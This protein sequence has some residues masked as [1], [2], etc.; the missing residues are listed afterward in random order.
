LDGAG[1]PHIGYYDDSHAD[2]KYIRWTGSAWITQTVDSGGNVGQ[3]TSL[4]LDGAGNP[5]ISYY[6][7]TNGDLKYARWTGSAGSTALTA[8]WSIQTVDSGGDVGSHASLALDAAGNPHISYYDDTNDDLKYARW[9]A[10]SEAEGTGS[11]WNIQTVD[12]GGSVGLYTSLALDT[13]GHPHISYYAFYPAY[14]LKYARWAGS[15]WEIQTVDGAGDVGEYTSLALDSAGNPHISYYDKTNGD[16]KYAVGSPL[17]ITPTPTPTPIATLMATATPT[18]TPTKTATPTG[19]PTKTPTPTPTTG[20]GPTNTLTPTR[21]PA[22]KIYVPLILK[23]R[24][25]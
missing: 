20:P 10:L 2:L 1:Y 4:A 3:Y 7:R 5:H 16:L 24:W 14:D 13:A 21:L 22:H 18:R 8:G 11:A 17:P 25:M 23:G 12:S 19:T 6:D 9:L 15:T